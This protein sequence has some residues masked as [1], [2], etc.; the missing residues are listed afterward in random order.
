VDIETFQHLPNSAIARLVREQGPKVCVFPINGTRRWFMLEHLSEEETDF[1]THYLDIITR[2]HIDLYKL[3]FDHGIDTL[4]TPALGPDIME[5]GQDYMNMA[6]EGLARLAS[7]PD[8]LSFFQAYDVRV[9][10]YGDYCK[11]LAST[12][13]A[14]L[15]DQFDKVAAQTASHQRHR[16]FFG[17]FAHDASES[18]AEIAVQF[19][20]THGQLPSRQEI[21]KAYYGE[22]VEPV[23]VFIGFDKFSAFDMP[24]VATGNEDLYFTVS[25]SLYM[26]QAQ[27]REILYDHMFARRQEEPDYDAMQANDW[28]LMRE[29]YKLNEGRTLGVGVKQR[30]GGFWYPLPQVEW[31]DSLHI[32]ATGRN[33]SGKGEN[34][35]RKQVEHLLKEMGPGRMMDTAYDTAWIARLN[36]FG[37]PIGE[38]ALEW[39]RANQLPD[40]SWGASEIRYNHDRL[41]CTLAAVTALA[42]VGDPQDRMR[43]ERAQVA[44]ET[45]TQG[46][47]ADP[48]GNTIGFEMIVPTLLA[49]A[50][51][52]G[53]IQ[54]HSGKE[55][56]HLGHYRAAK[57][58]S[59][60]Q[61]MINRYVTVAFSAE[62]AGPDGLHLLDI[63]NLQEPDGS[64]GYSPSA[65][66][67]F[68]LYVRRQDPNALKY[69]RQVAASGSAPNV[70]PF[71]IFEPA[72]ALWNLA[73]TNSLDER[74]L[75]LCQPHLEFLENTW[76]PGLGAGFAASYAPKD[77]DGT[78][79]VYEVL[80]HFGRSVD[81]ESVLR[82]E[83]DEYFRCYALEANPSLS[84]NIHILGALREAGLE[85]N[86]PSVAKIVAFLKRTQTLKLFWLDKW[87]ASP[88]YTTAHAI[89][90]SAGYVDQLVEDAVYW[91]LKTQ[92][93]DGSWGYYRSTAEETA[94]SL[95][96]LVLWKRYGH[97]VPDDILKR[98][99]AWLAQHSDPP[100][101][102]LW[103]GKCLYSPILVV[104]SAVLSALKLVDQ[105]S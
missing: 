6:S 91:I 87:H 74:L 64:V 50:K 68:S 12:P 31:P 39:L 35:W 38:K 76:R 80:T 96:A 30:H 94:Y 72:W 84:T 54:N 98:G 104:S 45:A 16:L 8:F 24:L 105:E 89:I 46:L 95:Q 81:L 62:M 77:G 65:T 9:R 4:L 100:Y 79:V 85:A 99:A 1:A 34:T 97:S 67:Y 26:T 57:L 40:G 66:A 82:Y 22:F 83:E 61:G 3:I 14:Y 58:A 92:N 101:P 60:P 78:S 69:L 5:R 71:D 17:L 102:P 75:A 93:K 51:D 10:F 27:L 18:V 33:G 43:F 48:T 47:G 29:F 32:A 19:H 36:E 56:D 25:P 88:Y 23:D 53:A 55:L 44:L 63:D 20:Q 90:A 70:A 49:E 86:H 42:R 11:F 2:Q 15:V 52:L 13:Y 28:E 41:I 73:L 37:E 59:L 21:V 103:I 7:H